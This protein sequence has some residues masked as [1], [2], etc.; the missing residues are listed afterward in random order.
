MNTE[1]TITLHCVRKD[2]RRE[3][4]KISDHT[5]ADARELAEWLL[6][7]GNGL[8]TQVDICT[9][10]GTVETVRNPA[11]PSPVGTA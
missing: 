5:M 2:G 8:Y 10:D 3:R 11:V 6:Y 9:E 7:A 1:T 4:T